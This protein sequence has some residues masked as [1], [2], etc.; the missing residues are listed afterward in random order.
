MLIPESLDKAV[1]AWEQHRDA[2][3]PIFSD[4]TVETEPK[5]GK[6][7]KN[8]R[9]QA[10]WSF[11]TNNKKIHAYIFKPEDIEM[12][13]RQVV[14]PLYAKGAYG[15]DMTALLKD[16][17]HFEAFLEAIAFHN[18]LSLLNHE[19]LHP[20]GCPNSKEDEEKIDLAL[21]EGVKEA[22][23][24]LGA[25]DLV[26]KAGNVRNFVWDHVDDLFQYY[27]ITTDTPYRR[28]LESVLA[29]N[30]HSVNG[31]AITK[32]PEG[33]IPLFDVVSV[34]SFKTAGATGTVQTPSAL[35]PL[36][37]IFYAMLFCGDSETRNGIY[38]HFMRAIK[39]FRDLDYAQFTEQRANS[40]IKKAMLGMVSELDSS[41]LSAKGISYSQFEAAVDGM[42][43]NIAKPQYSL[44][45]REVLEGLAAV[46]MDKETRYKAVKGFIKPLAPYISIQHSEDRHE[47]DDEEEGGG[48]GA[49]SALENLLGQLPK[50][51]ANQLLQDIANSGQPATAKDA[52]LQLQAIDEHYK[53]N[54]KEVALRSPKPEVTTIDLGKVKEWQPVRSET[55]TEQEL[56]DNYNIDALIEFAATTGLPVLQKLDENNWKISY[57]EEKELPLTSYTFQSTGIELPRNVVFVVDTS[58]SMLEGA[59]LSGASLQSQIAALTSSRNGNR[60]VGTGNKYD[61]LMNVVYGLLK[62]MDKA[63]K[64]YGAPV[65]L[66]TVNYSGT[67]VANGPVSV[68]DALSQA[69]SPVK[70]NLLS[71]QLGVTTLDAL[72]LQSVEKQL[73]PGKTVWL[74]FCDGDLRGVTTPVFQQFAKLAGKKDN[75]I[76]YFQLYDQGGAFGGFMSQLAAARPNVSY[77]HITDMN[78]VTKAAM[79]VLVKYAK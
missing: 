18:S 38:E 2:Q 73:Q 71:P 16:P 75:S 3:F 49:S 65:E 26:Q 58:T 53:R 24:Q 14:V 9:Q 37:R 60:F 69:A 77:N 57:F 20:A 52:K 33:I 28:N 23:P 31:T 35:Y 34:A 72:V 30:S 78:Q 36:T 74:V 48:G 51:E 43:K 67:T 13:F 64:D 10:L 42:F 56:R 61:A 22:M 68:Q 27:F 79:S 12:I 8:P 47:H 29:A 15:K 6:L 44:P 17:Q 39:Q 54:A 19:L 5:K 32:F 1:A 70:T 45:H 7:G 21:Y 11:S 66:V 76:V 4:I 41:E 55:V 59:R 62:T 25:K 63:S 40:L 46:L 50:D